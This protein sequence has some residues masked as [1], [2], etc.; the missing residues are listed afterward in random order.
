[1]KA[2]KVTANPNFL[3]T[4]PFPSCSVISFQRLPSL[5]S[6]AENSTPTVLQPV[7][8]TA[9]ASATT[10]CSFVFGGGSKVTVEHHDGDLFLFLLS[11]LPFAFVFPSSSSSACTLSPRIL[12]DLQFHTA[13]SFPVSTEEAGAVG[14]TTTA[15]IKSAGMLKS[16]G[17]Q[18]GVRPPFASPEAPMC[19]HCAVPSYSFH[20]A[21]SAPFAGSASVS[22]A[23][24]FS[25]LSARPLRLRKLPCACTVLSKS[26]PHITPSPPRELTGTARPFL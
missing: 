7:G 10:A 24:S 17:G 9:A 14:P 4:L 22:V 15:S 23:G 1:V 20:V 21:F 2:S 25:V 8:A 11:L 13:S 5:F 3:R 16:G 19:V 18:Q 12:P 26:A 6:R